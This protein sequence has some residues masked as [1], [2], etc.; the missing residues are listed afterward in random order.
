MSASFSPDDFGDLGL[1]HEVNVFVFRVASNG[2]E[3]LLLQP[4]PMHENVWRPVV[5]P[6]GLD[7]HL[8]HAALRGVREETGLARPFDLIHANAAPIRDLGDM[9]LIGWPFAFQVS[10]PSVIIHNN[11]QLAD[12]SWQRLEDA[13]DLITDELHRQ[14]LLQLHMKL[15]A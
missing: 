15:V 2:I 11:D 8:Q 9:R 10:D 13:L 3:Y 4:N 5:N 6:V 7:E 1:R 12:C 14:N